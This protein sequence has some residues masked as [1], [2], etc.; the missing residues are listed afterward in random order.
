MHP[1]AECHGDSL[2]YAVN[3][4]PMKQVV[5]YPSQT[6]TVPIHRRTEERLGWPGRQNRTK[7]VHATVGALVDCATT[8]RNPLILDEHARAPT[9]TSGDEEILEEVCA[10]RLVFVANYRFV[11]LE[12]VA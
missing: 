12:T 7:K 11:H 5:F 6:S 2:V 4:L 8:R 1:C 9:R 3:D 10:C